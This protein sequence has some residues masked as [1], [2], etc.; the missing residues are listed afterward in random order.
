MN[1]LERLRKMFGTK[2]TIKPFMDDSHKLPTQKAKYASE[3]LPTMGAILAEEQKAIV[4]ANRT[5]SVQSVKVSQAE[6]IP[7]LP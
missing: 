2:G 5:K 7:F 4:N 3:A 6:I 1:N